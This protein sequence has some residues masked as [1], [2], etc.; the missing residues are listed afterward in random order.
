MEFITLNGQAAVNFT[1]V[2]NC[3]IKYIPL[4]TVGKCEG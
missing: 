3:G 2:Y 1:F 4:S